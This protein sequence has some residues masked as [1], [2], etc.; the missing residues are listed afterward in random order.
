MGD[1]IIKT[2][3]MILS[4]LMLIFISVSCV[5]AVE[6]NGTNDNISNVG[7]NDFTALSNEI[8]ASSQSKV[9]NLTRDYAYNS[10]NDQQFCKGIDIDIDDLIIDGQ[11][12]TI[13]ANNE[14][15]IFN[16]NSDNV[17]LKNLVLINGNSDSEG[18]S[19]YWSGQNGQLINTVVKNSTSIN[20]KNTNTLNIGGGIY[21]KHA[22]T[23]IDSKFTDNYATFGGA[24][25][26][27]SSGVIKNCEFK[28]NFAKLLGG[29]VF[30]NDKVT[31]SNSTFTL[32]EASDGGAVYFFSQGIVENTLFKRNIAIGYGGAIENEN[33]VTI[34]NSS[35][36]KNTGAYAG[37]IYLKGDANIENSTLSENSA[38][39]GGAIYS[40]TYDASI[41]NCEFNQNDA[42][43]GKSLFISNKY[44]QIEN[45]TFNNNISYFESEI[46][47]ECNNPTLTNLTYNNITKKQPVENTTK[48]AAKKVTKKKTAITAG[49]KSFKLKKVKK[50]TVTLKTGKNVLKN[51]KIFIKVKNK[52][53]SGKTN[54]KGKVTF[55]LKITKKGKFKAIIK[56]FGDKLYK[57]SQ[58]TVYIKIKK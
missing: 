45:C 47:M 19:I 52:T 56:F 13:N 4:I 49:S 41:K 58:K 1:L 6:T 3:I 12:H 50:Y 55:K 21:F 53:Y 23:I 28:N 31:I 36:I 40:A 54:S 17:V 25:N 43:E 16:I 29:G 5:N 44:I 42:Q 39:I 38:K 11:G 10:L 24:I 32:N 18:A 26:F 48:P 8:N 34:K 14:A 27:D 33:S 46:Q 2:K 51:K 37:A 9:L 35:F 15:R 22:A 57:A 30:C 7:S 20:L